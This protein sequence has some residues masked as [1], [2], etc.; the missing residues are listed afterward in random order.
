MDYEK[1]HDAASDPEKNEGQTQVVLS[2]LDPNSKDGT[3]HR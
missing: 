2:G 1:K 3:V